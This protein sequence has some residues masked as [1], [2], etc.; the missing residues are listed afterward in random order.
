MGKIS[1]STR[2]NIVAYNDSG[3]EF[4]ETVRTVDEIFEHEKLPDSEAF[5][6]RN[7]ERHGRYWINQK[8]C[9]RVIPY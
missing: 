4:I 2:C 3:E 1:G 7:L 8:R 6:E 9:I 5:V